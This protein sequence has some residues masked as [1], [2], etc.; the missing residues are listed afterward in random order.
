MRGWVNH[1]AHHLRTIRKSFIAITST[2]TEDVANKQ[3]M[4]NNVPSQTKE[5]KKKK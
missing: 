1:V 3:L 4:P 2:T 5:K